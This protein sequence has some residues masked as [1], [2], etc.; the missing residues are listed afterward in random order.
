MSYQSFD[1]KKGA[2][3]ST[4]KLEALRLPADMKGLKVLDI[5][6]NAGFFSLEAKRRGAEYV[7][8][9]DI[10]SKF[11]GMAKENASKESLDVDF[12]VADMTKL[13][14]DVKFDI[15]IF[16]SALH[17][18]ESPHSLFKAI[19]NKLSHN[20]RLILE[21][22]VSRNVGRQIE[23]VS[24]SIDT[25]YY[26]TEELLFNFWLE[27]FAPRYVGASVPQAGDPI[28]RK[29]YHCKLKQTSVLF[30]FGESG[31]GKTQLAREFKNSI[32][33]STDK[34][35]KPIRNPNKSHSNAAMDEYIAKLEE[36]KSIRLAW[37]HVKINHE[38]REMFAEI[39]RGALK[40]C[41]G[42]PLVIIE[43][44]AA[45]D[46]AKLC[47]KGMAGFKFWGAMRNDTLDGLDAE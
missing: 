8:G 27:D 35:F 38:Y 36:T 20:G 5:G 32:I 42:A 43:G 3:D 47:R 18:I 44:Y 39:V 28:P 40:A 34:M 15:I 45:K 19:A 26:A 2:S 7:L 29:V 16:T 46:I 23:F 1:N 11:I 10:N 37:D 12:R 14:V 4:K 24:R 33:L 13:D 31:D 22:G 30:I 25:R 17:Y 41:A 9:I 6:C 21:C